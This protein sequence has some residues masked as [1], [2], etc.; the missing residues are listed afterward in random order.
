MAKLDEM[1]S[2]KKRLEKQRSSAWNTAKNFSNERRAYLYQ[3]LYRT[4]YP[5]KPVSVV[6]PIYDKPETIRACLNAIAEQ[7][8]P[9][10]ELIVCDDADTSENHLLVLDFAKTVSF[11]VKYIPTA[12]NNYG[13]ARARNE[14]IIAATGEVIVFIDQRQIPERTAITELLVSLVPKTWVYGNKNG[15]KDFV[16]NFSAIYRKDIIHMGMFNE[17]INEYGGMSQYCR[18]LAKANGIRMAYVESAKAN[19]MGKSS[20]KNRKR[21]QIIRMKTRLWKMDL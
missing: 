17:R 20:N 13:L 14:G 6:V 9:N 19:P 4:L 7:D 1:M 8:Y 3:K 5:Q 21:E 15:K 16:E 10:L 12:E 11:P 18:S 2:D